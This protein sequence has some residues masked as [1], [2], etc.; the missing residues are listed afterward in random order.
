M[1][2]EDSTENRGE[3]ELWVV[4]RGL[5]GR[6]VENWTKGLKNL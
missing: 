2:V 1:W 6:G 3:R 5:H 4:G